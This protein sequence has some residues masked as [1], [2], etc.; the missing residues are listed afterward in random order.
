MSYV[1]AFVILMACVSGVSQAQE[2]C[3]WSTDGAGSYSP[4]V[5]QFESVKAVQFAC[6]AN[7]VDR[8]GLELNGSNTEDLCEHVSREIRRGFPGLKV[9]DLNKQQS[10]PEKDNYL[11]VIVAVNGSAWKAAYCAAHVKVTVVLVDRVAEKG[12]AADPSFATIA[13]SR[14]QVKKVTK[15]AITAILDELAE[16]WHA[17]HET[18]TMFP[19][20]GLE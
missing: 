19:R 16:G 6:F 8:C 5:A 10:P 12:K 18:A 2:M 20:F 13:S 9:Y 3:R 7:G 11:Q 1:A 15:D 17:P 14:T 4:S